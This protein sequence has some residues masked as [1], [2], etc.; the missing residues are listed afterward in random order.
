MVRIIYNLSVTTIAILLCGKLPVEIDLI[1]L[2][3]ESDLGLGPL[4]W[5]SRDE[6]AMT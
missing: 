4:S 2:N 5:V 1:Y 6:L 3:A